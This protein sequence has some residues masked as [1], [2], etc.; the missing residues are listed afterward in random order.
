[1]TVL[2]DADGVNTTRPER[3]GAGRR[4]QPAPTRTGPPRANS[5]AS[6]APL[7]RTET[8]REGSVTAAGSTLPVWTLAAGGR[9][10]A[11]R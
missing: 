10:A 2:Q 3:A 8:T 7:L 5:A 9:W 11:P 1:M 4:H 6:A